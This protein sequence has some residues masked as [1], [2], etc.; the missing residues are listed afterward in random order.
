[1]GFVG[2]GF[3]GGCLVGGLVVVDS[4][5]LN[6]CGFLELTFV[7]ISGVDSLCNLRGDVM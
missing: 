2:D 1:M 3:L 4:Q 5:G 6:F 7:W